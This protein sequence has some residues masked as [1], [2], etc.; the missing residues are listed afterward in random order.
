MTLNL[1]VWKMIT[2]IGLLNKK[3]LFKASIMMI[4]G[5]IN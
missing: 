2:E 1:L 5:E 4:K 3:K